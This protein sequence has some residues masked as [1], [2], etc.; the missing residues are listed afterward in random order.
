M[1][2]VNAKIKLKIVFFTYNF[3]NC[4]CELSSFGCSIA[5]YFSFQMKYSKQVLSLLEC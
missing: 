5:F 4:N 1:Y 3:N 2:T